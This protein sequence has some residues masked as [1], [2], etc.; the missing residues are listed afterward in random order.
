MKILSLINKYLQLLF[1]FMDIFLSPL[2]LLLLACKIL[3]ERSA[4]LFDYFVLIV[5]GGLALAALLTG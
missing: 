5:L 4:H 3:N 2:V 1:S